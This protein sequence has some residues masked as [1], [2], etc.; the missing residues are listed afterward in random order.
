VAVVKIFDASDY[1]VAFVVGG[2]MSKPE[3]LLDLATGV[4]VLGG[5]AFKVTVEDLGWV[6]VTTPTEKVDPDYIGTYGPWRGDRQTVCVDGEPMSFDDARAMFNE[7][8]LSNTNAAR[9]VRR[10]VVDALTPHRNARE[11]VIDSCMSRVELNGQWT[12]CGNTRG[13]TGRCGRPD[14]EEPMRG[15]DCD[16]CSGKR[17]PSCDSHAV[18][19]AS[20]RCASCV[21]PYRRDLLVSARHAGY[22]DRPEEDL[23]CASCVDMMDKQ[24]ASRAEDVRAEDIRRINADPDWHRGQVGHRGCGLEWCPV[25]PGG[26]GT[27]VHR[28]PGAVSHTLDIGPPSL[29]EAYKYVIG[30]DPAKPGSD[31]TVHATTKLGADGQIVSMSVGKAVD[32]VVS[33]KITRAEAEGRVNERRAEAKLNK[34]HCECGYVS[35]GTFLI[36]KTCDE[37]GLV[38]LPAFDPGPRP[39]VSSAIS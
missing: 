7:A 26:R 32:V 35:S 3:P 12:N 39:R 5:R 22:E 8:N 16:V 30:V 4:V 31:H 29:G 1:R 20:G 25:C 33:E 18:I 9:V 21:L 2:H 19:G 6:A 13:H 17:T 27:I 15:E 24:R 14:V 37:A 23:L 28:A 36:C 38:R 34:R 10:K 11:I